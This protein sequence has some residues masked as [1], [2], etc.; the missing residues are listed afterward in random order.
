MATRHGAAAGAARHHSGPLTCCLS[1]TPGARA[2]D[3]LGLGTYWIEPVLDD[4]SNVCAL[5]TLWMR[6]GGPVPEIHSL[7]MSVA[8]DYTELIMRWTRQ[9]LHLQ[10]AAVC[11]TR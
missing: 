10:D 8:K 9:R 6:A 2:A 11:V 4:V 1:T 7:G 5:V 3:E